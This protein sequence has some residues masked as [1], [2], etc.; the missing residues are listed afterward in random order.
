MR[1]LV[2]EK[3]VET[4]GLDVPQTGLESKRPEPDIGPE[5][6]D[7]KDEVV[8]LFFSRSEAS[9]L[10]RNISSHGTLLSGVRS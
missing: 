9:S 2:L 1:T 7:R 3:S 8:V 5:E 6:S 10:R 4:T